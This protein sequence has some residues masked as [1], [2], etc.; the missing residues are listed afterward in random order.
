MSLSL[1]YKDYIIQSTVQFRAKKYDNRKDFDN[2][3]CFFIKNEEPEITHRC[4]D[5]ILTRNSYAF[6]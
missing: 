3:F 5:I 2:E 6:L 4:S 1:I